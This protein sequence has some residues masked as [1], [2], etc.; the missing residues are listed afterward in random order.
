[1]SETFRSQNVRIS[2]LPGDCLS[3]GKL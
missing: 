1:L 2:Q 3:F